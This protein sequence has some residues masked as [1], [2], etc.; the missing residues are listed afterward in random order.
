MSGAAPRA[1]HWPLLL[2]E[3]IRAAAGRQPGKVAVRIVDRG[4][5]TEVVSYRQFVERMN[6]VSHLGLN[7]LGL[8]AGDR[9]AIASANS[10][11]FMLTAC[12]LG[13]IG[14]IVATPNPKLSAKEVRAICDD[15]GARV[16]FCGA[17]LHDALQAEEYGSV[18]RVVPFDAGFDGM[19]GSAASH[20][21]DASRLADSFSD[22]VLPYTSG[23]TGQPKGV[24]VNHISRSLTFYGMGVEYG[25]FG[26][27]DHFV[28]LAP[29]CHGAGFAFNFAPLYFGASCDLMTGFQP[30]VLLRHL[31]R[32][33]PTGIFMVPT[34]F[35]AVFDQPETLLAG[36]GENRLK[37]IISNAAPLGQE[38]KE[39]IVERF[40]D[41]RLHECYGS[42]EGGV[43][44]SLRPRDQLR[45][46]Q[47]VGLPFVNTEIKLVD[48][49][50]EAVERGEVG[51]LFSRSPYLFAGYWNKPE[52]TA[53]SKI[54]GWVSAGDL[55][56]QDDEGFYYIV[57][58][59]KDMIITGGINVYP[60]EVETVLNRHSAV[61]E[62]AVYGV[63]DDY[64]GERI[65]AALVMEPGAAVPTDDSLQAFCQEHIGKQKMPRSFVV[66]T[67]LPRN[68]MG[69]VLK[70]ALREQSAESGN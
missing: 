23:T 27:D 61:L 22:F 52:E 55:A 3:G 64:W 30:D 28:G 68:A 49:D 70:S 1:A 15:S 37:S 47:C 51:E 25:C 2:S 14:V 17:A 69:K 63:P 40:G 62:S 45:K 43:V 46:L 4:E 36:C 6:R 42:T 35:R 59:K 26:P 44:T 20:A 31:E 24:R 34:H 16:L 39:I 56:R 67:A 65:V 5:I 33:Q 38:M 32:E 9:V 10:L 21:P 57:D 66:H 19:L 8:E 11:Q 54:D 48:D 12:G 7:E 50:G 13:A 53:K 60:K 18:Q 29:L 58:R 41:G